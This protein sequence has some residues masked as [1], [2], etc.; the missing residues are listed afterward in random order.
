MVTAFRVPYAQ[1]VDTAIHVPFAY[2]GHLVFPSRHFRARLEY[3]GGSFRQDVVRFVYHES[4]GRV[5]LIIHDDVQT[6]ILLPWFGLP[7]MQCASHRSL[8]RMIRIVV[9]LVVMYD[10]VTAFDT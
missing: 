1:V 10:D 2:P 7:S 4:C 6:V 5:H 9:P 3:Y 8:Y